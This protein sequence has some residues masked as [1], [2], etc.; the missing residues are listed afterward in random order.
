MGGVVDREKLM[1]NF[2][3]G[4]G[5]PQLRA[6]ANLWKLDDG[7][8]GCGILVSKEHL[9]KLYSMG[10]RTLITLLPNPLRG[11][12]NYC[13]AR[14]DDA[15]KSE[16]HDCDANML[17]EC[18]LRLVHVPV[19]DGTA[20]TIEDCR[21]IWTIVDATS[22]DGVCI[23][24]W[25]GRGRTGTVWASYLMHRDGL[26]SHDAIDKVTEALSKVGL[27]D[28]TSWATTIQRCFLLEL[29]ETSKLPSPYD[30]DDDYK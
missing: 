25:L 8:Y 26:N 7:L 29:D 11:G 9:D 13:N 24:C 16:W 30:S 1:G 2:L 5:D 18:K 23:H 22:P 14:P 27:Y 19:R 17:E 12:R 20:P 10:V 15:N 4:E 21:R 3:V 28:H 6:P